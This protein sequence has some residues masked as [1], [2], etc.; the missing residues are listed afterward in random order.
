MDGSIAKLAGAF[1]NL[2]IAGVD[3]DIFGFGVVGTHAA[4]RDGAQAATQEGELGGLAKSRQIGVTEVPTDS[5]AE[6][7]GY[8]TKLYGCLAVAVCGIIS[9]Y[10]SHVF[11]ND[12]YANLICVFHKRCQM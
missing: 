5:D 12:I 8:I 2:A 1:Q 9:V 4:E 11:N 10:L 6:S 3:T 7:V